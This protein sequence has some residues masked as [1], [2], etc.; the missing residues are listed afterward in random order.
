MIQNFQNDLNSFIKTNFNY[1]ADPTRLGY[2]NTLDV[3]RKRVKLYIRFKT[4][5]NPWKDDTLVLAGINFQEQRKGNGRKLL[6]FLVNQAQKYKYQKIGIE[7]TN[8]MSTNFANKYGFKNISE[9]KHWIV[10]I[11]DLKNE[12]NRYNDRLTLI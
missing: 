1:K 12:L 3:N 7:Q 6:S 4:N 2:G 9:N 8:E 5:C 11:S 10:S